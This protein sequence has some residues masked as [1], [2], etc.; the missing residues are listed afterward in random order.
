[1]GTGCAYYSLKQVVNMT[2]AKGKLF[3]KTF[4]CQM[5]VHD[6]EKLRKILEVDYETAT[7]PEDADLILVNTCSVRERPSQ[8]LFSLLGEYRPLKKARPDLLI[9]VCGCVAQQLGADYLIILA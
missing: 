4:G 1:M 7:R 8:K 5:N 2:Q 9:G 6:S 3:I